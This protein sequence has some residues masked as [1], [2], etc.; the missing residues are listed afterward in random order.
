MIEIKNISN[1]DLRL[2]LLA[3]DSLYSGNIEVKP[4]TIREV[5]D[6]GY[7]NYNK[8]LGVLMLKK[9]ELI[10]E[11]IPELRDL[12]VFDIILIS[13]NEILI[14]ALID[15]LCFFL[16]EDRDKI[17]ASEV[18]LIFGF[19]D[20]DKARVVNSKNFSEIVEIVKYQNCV[21]NSNE[22]IEVNTAVDDRAKKIAEKIKKYKEVI[23]KK[24]SQSNDANDIDF[25][26]IVSAVSTKS[27]TYNKHTIWDCTVYQ[28]YDEY[29]RLEMISGYET[30]I[31]AMV[32]G[33]K[34][35]NLKHWSAKMEE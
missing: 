11:D 5:K 28:L 31:L 33:A 30:N 7:L 26:D 13:G 2:R 9:E 27:N 29:K 6:V 16:K 14:D 23:T 22:M 32:N 3:G 34:I 17:T 19:E 8:Y 1:F 12:T 21:K 35:D 24:K 25:A 18:G 10:K 20:F 15:A 4:L